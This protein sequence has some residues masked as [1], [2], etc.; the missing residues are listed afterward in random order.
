MITR[1]FS[2][3]AVHWIMI[4]VLLWIAFHLLGSQTSREWCLIDASKRWLTILLI[5]L[6]KLKRYAEGSRPWKSFACNSECKLEA[7]TKESRNILTDAKMKISKS[8][9]SVG[10]KLIACTYASSP[11]T[12]GNWRKIIFFGVCITHS[13]LGKSLC[14][15]SN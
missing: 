15:L 9:I 11:Q 3:Q 1:K 7:L 4:L 12:Y 10:T 13:D 2:S 5:L 6:L 8:S 14:L